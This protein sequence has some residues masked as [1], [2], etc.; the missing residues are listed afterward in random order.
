MRRVPGIAALLVIAS[1][2]S[3]SADAYATNRTRWNEMPADVREGYVMGAYDGLN[4]LLDDD[5]KAGRAFKLG[6]NACV[7]D[8]KLNSADLSKLVTE[9]YEA[10][11]SKW[12][13]PPSG[14]LIQQLYKVCRRYIDAELV[15]VRLPT[16]KP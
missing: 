5:D 15:K 2:T 12:S 1:A 10:D 13:E 6:R 14:I 8:L 7:T 3:A 16:T 11:V 4:M 9:G